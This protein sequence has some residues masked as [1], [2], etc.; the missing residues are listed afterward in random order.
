MYNKEILEMVK[1]EVKPAIGCTEPVAVAFAAATANKYLKEDIEKAT[2]KVSVNIYKNGKSVFIPGTDECGLEL[3]AA[4]GI[5]VGD[6]DDGLCVFK[7][8]DKDSIIKAKAL[9]E[10][11][12]ISVEPLKDVEGI[13]IEAEVKGKNNIVKAIVSGGHTNVEKIIVN[14]NAIYKNEVEKK[15]DDYCKFIRDYSFVDLKKYAEN[16]P[17]KDIEFVLQGVEMNKN[18]ALEGLKKKKGFNLGEG[19]LKVHEENEMNIDPSIKARI[20]TAAGADYRM[21]GGILPI[22]TSGGSGNQ[23]IG[24]ILPISVIA[25]KTNASDEEL[26]RAIFF[27]HIVNIYIKAYVGKL[28]SMCGCAIASGVGASAGIAWIIGGNDEQISG[29][30][31]NMLSNLT[32]MICDGAKESCA[33]KLSTS[34]GE[35]V[36]AAYLACSDVIVPSNT[37]IVGKTVEDTIKNIQKLCKE[38]LANTDEILLD[39]ICNN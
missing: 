23:G 14:D 5:Q 25:E 1:K 37:G 7:N 24:V 9:I 31:K 21:G 34:A 15:Q 38:G 17:F 27:A 20:L 16:I 33:Y 30:V 12:K 6:S 39:I 2:V 29:A 22:M 11:G 10:Q 19:L 18:A 13:Y 32:G 4:L 35:A 28:S 8:V 26:A 3:A 36:I